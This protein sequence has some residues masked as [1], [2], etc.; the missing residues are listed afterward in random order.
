MIGARKGIEKL[1]MIGENCRTASIGKTKRNEDRVCREHK[2]CEEK[3]QMGKKKKEKKKKTCGFEKEKKM[4]KKNK[5][6]SHTTT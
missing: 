2:S 5:A 6:R 3:R 1:E 4:E